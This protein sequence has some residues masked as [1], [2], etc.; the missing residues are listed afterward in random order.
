MLIAHASLHNMNLFQMDV[1]TAFLNGNLDE[2]IYM[3]GIPGSP[4]EAGTALKLH[5]ALYGLKQA[6][7]QW[8]LMVSTALK[9]FGF[10]SCDGDN[11]LFRM[12]DEDG[13]VLLALYV[14]DILIATNNNELLSRFENFICARFQMK[15]LGEAK[16][17]LGLSITRNAQGYSICQELYTKGLVTRFGLDNGRTSKTPMDPGFE[18]TRLPTDTA[19]TKPPFHYRSAIGC[20]TYLATAS[21]P[22]IATAVNILAQ[23]QEGP[24]KR[25]FEAI[26]L[27]MRYL[28]GTMS[29]KINYSSS[30]NRSP[31]IYSDSLPSATIL[32][33]TI[34]RR[35]RSLLAMF[36]LLLILLI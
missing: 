26:R 36:K 17:C 28:R 20:L 6:A 1:V 2:T 23:F 25:H 21:R 29:V 10:I 19:L 30:G 5:K 12:D 35:I 24:A 3:R 22:D 16:Q 33:R 8:Y 14:D 15:L 31:A 32:F 27:L 9:E 34:S 18:K 11:C 13:D 7:R 4:L